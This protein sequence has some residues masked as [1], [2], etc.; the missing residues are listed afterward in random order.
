[1]RGNCKAEELC[2]DDEGKRGLGGAVL[3]DPFTNL[4]KDMGLRDPD[5]ICL[6]SGGLSREDA[7]A[8]QTSNFTEAC[9]EMCGCEGGTS[10]VE[11]SA[12]RFLH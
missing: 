9:C 12:T 10:G 7:P 8:Q 11:G 6:T 3:L 5:Q 1:M 2:A 4:R